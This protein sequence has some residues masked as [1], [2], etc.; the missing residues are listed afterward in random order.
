MHMYLYGPCMLPPAEAQTWIVVFRHSLHQIIYR[1]DIG[2]PSCNATVCACIAR[3]DHRIGNELH[4][5]RI[6]WVWHTRTLHNRTMTTGDVMVWWQSSY[7]MN[8]SRLGRP[9]NIPWLRLSY[10]SL[11]FRCAS[12]AATPRQQSPSWL[13]GNI[14]LTYM[15]DE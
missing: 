14:K 8:D 5:C 15:I 13:R 11:P 7:S 1:L 12:S 4:I 9:F 3:L 6:M 2:Y 10:Q